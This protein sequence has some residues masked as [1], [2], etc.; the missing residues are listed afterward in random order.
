MM[1]M[2]F[3]MKCGLMGLIAAFLIIT[4]MAEFYFLGRLESIDIHLNEIS[5]HTIRDWQS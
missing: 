1:D 4:L 2:Y 5:G 3:R